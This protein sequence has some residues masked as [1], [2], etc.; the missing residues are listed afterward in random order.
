MCEGVEGE[1][2]MNCVVCAKWQCG[3]M[4]NDRN[5][6]GGQGHCHQS[7][8]EKKSLSE[9]E[10]RRS[11]REGI[12]S[13]STLQMDSAFCCT[14]SSWRAE[15]TDKPTKEEQPYSRRGRM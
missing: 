14:A 2:Q 12:Q 10:L 1:W 11:E 6:T 3:Q 9:T 8:I 5:R 13:E 15:R 4:A 7:R